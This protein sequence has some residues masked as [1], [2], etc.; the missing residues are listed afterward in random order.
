M[1]D[2]ESLTFNFV[3]AGMATWMGSPLFMVGVVK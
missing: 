2:T 1:S 3:D